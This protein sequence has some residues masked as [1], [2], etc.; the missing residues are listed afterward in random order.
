MKHY[1]AIFSIVSGCTMLLTSASCSDRKSADTGAEPTID[2]ATV[3]VDSVTVH[4]TYPAYLTA[5]DE[6][7]LVARVNGYLTSAPYNDGDFVRAGTTLFTI[8]S[9]QYADDVRKAEAALK[10]AEATYSYAS[11]HYA[12]MQKA[13]QLQAVSQ[14]EMLQ[15]KNAMESA[16]A[17]IASSRAALQSARTTLAYCTVRA[18]FDG[19]VSKCIYS[20]GAYLAGGGAPVTLSTLYDDAVVNANF[21]VD[22]TDFT[23]IRDNSANPDIRR[24]MDAVSVTFDT[25]MQHSYKGKLGYISPAV[26]KSTGSINMQ[27]KIQNPYG[28]LRSGMYCT[29]HMPDAVIRDA[30]LIRD[31]SVSTDQLGQFV[32]VVNDSN[33]VVYTPVKT[34]E[35]VN[36]TMRV[37]TSGLK[38]GDRYVTKAMLMVRQGMKINPN[39]GK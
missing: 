32:Y 25:P 6:V 24:D 7:D 33:T 38:S 1:S 16:Q 14:M 5:I 31:A 22:E 39:T 34:G 20:V 21:S 26:D 10:D 9:T 2:V 8:E 4:K 17:A 15:A 3:T 23:A 13:L 11:Q 28:E 27:V 35:L 18:P 37:V 36:D 29:V 30:V 12:A 19:H